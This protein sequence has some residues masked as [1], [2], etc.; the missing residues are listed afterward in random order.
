MTKHRI[1]TAVIQSW[2]WLVGY[3]VICNALTL[4]AL[5]LE[6][7][8]MKVDACNYAHVIVVKYYW[9]VKGL[10]TWWVVFAFPKK[11]FVCFGLFCWR[12][13]QSL[14]LLLIFHIF[15]TWINGEKYP[16]R[17]DCSSENF[18]HKQNNTI[19]WHQGIFCPWGMSFLRYS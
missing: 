13:T 5:M 16:W 19:N 2:N 4:A 18:H 15:N 12:S 9:S 6:N 8:N 11:C 7:N 1:Y 3:T 14:V 10:Y 17:W